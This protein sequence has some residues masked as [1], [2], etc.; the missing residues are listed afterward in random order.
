VLQ[1]LCSGRVSAQASSRAGGGGGGERVTT[2]VAV[3]LV[4]DTVLSAHKLYEKVL[5]DALVVELAPAAELLK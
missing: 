1:W 4:H 3:V 2:A 5:L